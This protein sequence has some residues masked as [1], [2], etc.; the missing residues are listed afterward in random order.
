MILGSRIATSLQSH[1]VQKAVRPEGPRSGL[2]SR[3]IETDNDEVK[4][5]LY[6]SGL[7]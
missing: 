2:P 7:T 4:F 5:T 3:Q 6:T 1:R